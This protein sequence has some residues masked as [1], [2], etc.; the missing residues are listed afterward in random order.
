MCLRD[1]PGDAE[2]GRQD[3]LYHLWA[4]PSDTRGQDHLGA[5]QRRRKA[6]QRR[7]HS[8]LRNQ[9][10]QCITRGILHEARPFRDCRQHHRHGIHRSPAQLVAP[11]LDEQIKQDADREL[12]CY[13]IPKNPISMSG[14][15]ETKAEGVLHGEADQAPA[16]TMRQTWPWA[17]T[18][19]ASAPTAWLSPSRRLLKTI[20]ILMSGSPPSFY[21]F[22]N[23]ND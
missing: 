16:A 8:T 12:A 5:G 2:E 7:W 6:V 22:V 17:L 9:H 20:P 4:A 3:R 18:S 14:E 15:S 19:W 21:L 23:L 13:S 10:F 1:H 11:Y